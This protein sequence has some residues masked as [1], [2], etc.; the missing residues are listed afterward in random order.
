MD[1]GI[2]SEI[3][4]RYMDEH[5]ELPV[6]V[7]IFNAIAIKQMKALEKEQGDANIKET[8]RIINK[9]KSNEK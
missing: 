9:S 1:E 8:I 2:N 4:Q 5:Q 7:K 6:Y 3:L